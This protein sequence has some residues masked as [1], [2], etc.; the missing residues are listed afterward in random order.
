MRKR[1]RIPAQSPWKNINFLRLTTCRR[2]KVNACFKVRY[3]WGCSQIVYPLH[4]SFVVRM[5]SVPSIVVLVFDRL[6]CGW[7]GPYGNRWVPTPH[8]NRLAAESMLC[9]FVVSESCRLSEIYRGYW[10]RH[11]AYYPA[12]VSQ[13]CALAELARRAGYRPTFITDDADLA[14]SRLATSFEE[15]ILLQYASP[16]KCA[17]D[18][19]KTRV[20]DVLQ[21]ALEQASIAQ[22]PELL[23]IHASAMNA[24][25]DAPHELVTP[26][27]DEE[28]PASPVM[29]LPPTA[30]LPKTYDPDWLL[31]FT[32]NYAGQ[33]VATD[34]ALGMFLDQLRERSWLDNVWL[35]VTSS[36]GY[37]LGEHGHIGATGDGLH[38]EVL[39]VPLLIRAP[40]G[41]NALTRWP[42][43]WQ[44]CDLYSTLAAL[45]K[46][47]SGAGTSI[48]NVI[49]GSAT[50][51]QIA[52]ASD[53][54]ALAV[55]TPAWFYRESGAEHER[56]SAL[57][58]K[59]DDRWEANEI[60]Q[61]ASR[62]THEFQ[63]WFSDWKLH[64]DPAI[65]TQGT[66]P[67]NLMQSLQ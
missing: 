51:P 48:L 35:V 57:Y 17:T 53:D 60:S 33:V 59:P 49:A 43:L 5:N 56:I 1:L 6:G 47:P 67:A 9:E 14:H 41:E 24:A 50:V 66:L 31:G 11:P 38:G 61:R 23:W 3:D 36:R 64:C 32:H 16:Q 42:G 65:R 26:F 15:P 7:L 45:L 21:S 63:S 4:L 29:W 44:G 46:Q 25:W 12:E 40:Q 34:Y 28:D 37:P 2:C 27:A 18:T 19:Q 58:V 62:V 55:R 39:Q 30:V 22:T 52:L 13:E 10:M 54:L 8:W 20:Y